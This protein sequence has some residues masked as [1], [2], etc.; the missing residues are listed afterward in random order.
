[1]GRGA[2]RGHLAHALRIADVRQELL[3]TLAAVSDFSYAWGLLGGHVAR[4]QAE[5]RPNPSRMPCRP[6]RARALRRQK[7]LEGDM[8]AA[9]S[10]CEPGCAAGA[11]PLCLTTA[12]AQRRS[13][14]LGRPLLWGG[15][16]GLPPRSWARGASRPRPRRPHAASGR[17]QSEHSWGWRLGAPARIARQGQQSN[18][19]ACSSQ[20]AATPVLGVLRFGGSG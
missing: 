3:E 7:Q 16:G 15:A 12:A 8:V 13:A 17:R 18:R 14:P 9:C 1:M 2:R 20:V 6:E 10:R 11:R 19:A 5:A 4:L